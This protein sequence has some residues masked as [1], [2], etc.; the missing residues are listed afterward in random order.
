[1]FDNPSAKVWVVGEHSNA[2]IRWISLTLNHLQLLRPFHDHAVSLRRHRLSNH[3]D[4]KKT[5]DPLQ[6][7]HL[8]HRRLHLLTK[9]LVVLLPAELVVGRPLLG[10]IRLPVE[11]QSHVAQDKPGDPRLVP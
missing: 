11:P 1:M 3:G 9:V 8:W 2:I 4:R 5:L 7:R 10:G 6:S